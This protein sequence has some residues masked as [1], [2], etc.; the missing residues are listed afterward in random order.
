MTT[1]KQYRPSYVVGPDGQ[2]TA[3]L[4]DIAT[5]KSIIEQMEDTED[6][7]IIRVAAADLEALARGE[8]PAGWKSWEMFEAELD[9][10][11]EA[12]ELPA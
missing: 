10:L 4:V 1:V 7:E 11:E 5:W 6:A 2:P 8:R 9:A 12:G 3:V